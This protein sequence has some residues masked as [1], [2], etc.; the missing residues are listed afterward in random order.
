ME[1][2]W[3]KVEREYFT[4]Q[5]SKK[6]DV[7]AKIINKILEKYNRF[8]QRALLGESPFVAEDLKIMLEKTGEDNAGQKDSRSG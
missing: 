5:N 8:L 2:T 1:N 7:P 3:L 4:E 6:L